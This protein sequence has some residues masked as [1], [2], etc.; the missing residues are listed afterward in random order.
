MYF[1]IELEWTLAVVLSNSMMLF[2]AQDLLAFHFHIIL[3][4][5]K[6]I[7]WLMPLFSWRNMVGNFYHFTLWAQPRGASSIERMYVEYLLWDNIPS[8]C[9][10]IPAFLSYLQTGQ[11]H[12]IASMV[13][14]SN[15]LES[16]S[17]RNVKNQKCSN[18]T[19]AVPNYQTCLDKAHHLVQN[20]PGYDFKDY[21]SDLNP[22]SESLRWFL[23]PS[24]AVAH[25]YHIPI[26]PCPRPFTIPNIPHSTKWKPFQKTHAESIPGQ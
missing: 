5:K 23:L 13:F 11:L 21:K 16:E 20:M 4:C 12:S 26:M 10:F 19:S 1:S 7:S 14:T 18:E 22:D 2:S 8:I 25:A 3:R 17:S 24:E 6:L 9:R 15:G